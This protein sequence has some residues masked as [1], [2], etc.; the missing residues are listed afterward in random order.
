VTNQH[1]EEINSNEMRNMWIAV[2]VI[3]ILIVGGMGINMLVH[4]SSAD[5]VQTS[6]PAQ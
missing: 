5:T 4:D 2:G 6:N 3:V 1:E